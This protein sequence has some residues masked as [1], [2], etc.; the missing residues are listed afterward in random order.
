MVMEAQSGVCRIVLQRPQI[1][2]IGP[3]KL[4]RVRSRHEDCLVNHLI[5]AQCFRAG[6]GEY[7]AYCASGEEAGHVAYVQ[8]VCCY[9]AQSSDVLRA[10]LSGRLVS[11]A[12]MASAPQHPFWLE[13]L[14]EIFQSLDSKQIFPLCVGQLR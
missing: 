4:L 5:V 1:R 13:V 2:L 10:R 7:S 9:I 11:N 3:S 14:R 6:P 12:V 8:A